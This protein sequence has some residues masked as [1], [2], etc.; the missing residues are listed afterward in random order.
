[1]QSFKDVY[2]AMT[3][4]DIVKEAEAQ[5]SEQFGTD[6]SNVDGDL[7]KQAQDYDYIGRVLAHQV[8][9]DLVKEA[10]D[11]EMPHSSEEDKEKEKAKLMAKARGEGGDEKKD[12]DKDED[13]E[14]TEKKASIKQA[15][16]DRMAGDPDYV[17]HLISKHYPG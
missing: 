3:E 12:E 1:M 17:S 8:L 15:I 4:Q 5:A 16:M 11:E 14:E 9:G 13:E 6:M 7:V 10:M 2:F